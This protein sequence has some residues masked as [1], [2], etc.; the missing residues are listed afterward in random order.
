MARESLS[1]GVLRTFSFW[2]P[3]SFALTS[4]GIIGL[5]WIIGIHL[6]G[7]HEETELDQTCLCIY[8]KAMAVCMVCM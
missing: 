7:W 1:W 2:G 3:Q 5:S 6:D 8:S 4:Y